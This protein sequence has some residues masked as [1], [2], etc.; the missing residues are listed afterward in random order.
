MFMQGYWSK[1]IKPRDPEPQRSTKETWQHL[2]PAAT[3]C[4]AGSLAPSARKSSDPHT[5]TTRPQEL[6][7]GSCQAIPSLSALVCR[8]PGRHGWGG[9]KSPYLV[10]V[11]FFSIFFF[12]LLSLKCFFLSFKCSRVKILSTESAC[13]PYPSTVS[14][15]LCADGNSTCPTL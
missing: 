4:A 7:P 11:F 2:T 13:Q 1:S 14:C 3:R 12:F 9:G 10:Q 8:R 6:R 5:G 15:F